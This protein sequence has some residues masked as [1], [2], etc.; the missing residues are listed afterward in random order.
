[1]NDSLF[2]VVGFVEEQIADNKRYLVDLKCRH[3]NVVDRFRL[4]RKPMFVV[5][6][7]TYASFVGEISNGQL[8]MRHNATDCQI[9]QSEKQANQIANDFQAA[10]VD[11]VVYQY[12]EVLCSELDRVKSELPELQAALVKAQEM[13]A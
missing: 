5:G 6:S 11:V 9:F 10:G 13:A 2:D 1:M 3:D 12:I 4:T 8:A 7:A